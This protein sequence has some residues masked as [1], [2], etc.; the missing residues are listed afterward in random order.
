MCVYIY[1]YIPLSPTKTDIFQFR[2]PRR[3]DIITRNVVGSSQRIAHRVLDL[4]LL[5]GKHSKNW[6]TWV[7]VLVASTQFEKY[8][9]QG[10]QKMIEL[11]PR[12]TCLLPDNLKDHERS[13]KIANEL[14]H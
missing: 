12:R 6:S 5:V 10:E 14:L 8:A 1:I 9:F 3:C 2:N 13:V 7:D 4:G 11:P